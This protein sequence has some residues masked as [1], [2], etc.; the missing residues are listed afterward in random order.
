[1]TQG[2]KILVVDDDEQLTRTV[3]AVLRQQGFEPVL[4]HSAEE[5]LQQAR[6][7]HPDLAL[8]DVMMPVIGGWELCRR[9]RA[10]SDIPIVFLTALGETEDIVHGLE[11]GADDYLV[12]PF[13]QAE[14]LARIRAHLRR[15]QVSGGEEILIFGDGEL[16][17]DLASRRVLVDDA[18]VALTPREYQL[19]A[20]LVRNE[21]R[22]LRTADLIA[23]AWGE[24][25]RD[26][27]EN[28]KPY[29]HYLRKKIEKNPV[30]PRWIQTARG[31]GYRF[32]G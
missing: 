17:V 5:G 2:A 23:T 25:Y 12:K 28:I 29:I 22:V 13:N 32:V 31:I 30:V 7:A 4:A 26:T 15:S 16:V 14:L 20:V 11:L 8:L 21:G 9:L 19:L 27:P 3:A 24:A 18:E 1:M 6:R 10:Q